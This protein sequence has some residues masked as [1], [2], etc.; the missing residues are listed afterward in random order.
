MKKI[1]YF[2]A[3]VAA[4][5]MFAEVSV[6]DAGNINKENPYG[7]TEN[8]KVLLNNKKKVDRLDQ[9]IGSMQSDVSLVQENIEGVKSLL[10]G[11]NKRILA[12]ETRVNELENN[13]NLQKTTSTKDIAN[14]KSQIK[15]NQAQQDKDIKKITTALSEL[16][17][18]ISSKSVETTD[19]KSTNSES[20][21]KKSDTKEKRSDSLKLDD[22]PGAE[23]L[24]MADKAY[25]SKEY[26]KASE[27]FEHLIK[28][29]Y[30]PAYSNFMLGEISYFNKDYKSAIPYYEKSVAISQKG[31]YMPKLLYHTAISF[32][33]IGDTKS[34]NKFYKALK[35]A[36]PDSQEAKT[37]PDRK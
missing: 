17:S 23:V 13:L 12:I 34:A 26:L 4:T 9:N 5:S 21:D 32:D 33:K 37:A 2:A 22:M 10:D 18:L 31:N 25:K 8:E 3:I 14:L 36:Y 1:F 15:A 7:L 29:N 30:K 20:N 11:I 16:T 19:A 27:C 6:F 24:A 35:Q 28:K